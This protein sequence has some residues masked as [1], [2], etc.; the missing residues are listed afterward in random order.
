MLCLSSDRRIHYFERKPSNGL[1]DLGA[2]TYA[3]GAPLQRLCVCTLYRKQTFFGH[4]GACT[5]SKQPRCNLTLCSPHP[6]TS[7]TTMRA[8][9]PCMTQTM[10]VWRPAGA[11]SRACTCAVTAPPRSPSA[12]RPCRAGAG[13]AGSAGA[14]AGLPAAAAR[15]CRRRWRT[16]CRSCFT[17]GHTCAA[18]ACSRSRASPYFGL[19]GMQRGAAAPHALLYASPC[20]AGYLCMQASGSRGHPLC[21]A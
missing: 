15:P 9:Q 4:A 1:N 20:P 7:G 19:A 18:R 2:L 8:K 16:Q 11:G 13:P 5:G 12:P 6:A 10:R 21:A 3:G 14:A 17:Y